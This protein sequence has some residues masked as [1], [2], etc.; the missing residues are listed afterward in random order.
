MERL[1]VSTSPHI[2]SD[3]SVPKIMWTVVISLIPAAAAGCYFFGTRSDGTYSLRPIFVLL[4]SVAVAVTTEAVILFFRGKGARNALDGSAVITGMLFAMVCSSGIPWYIVVLGSFFSIAVA[5][6][7]FGGLGF[8]IWNPALIGRAFALMAWGVEM[9]KRWPV[10]LR[11]DALSGA[12]PLDVLK[13]QDPSVAPYSVWNLFTGNVPGCLGETSALLLLIGGFFLI[14][15]KYVDWRV[16]LS[17][18]VT[19]VILCLVIP[20]KKEMTLSWFNDLSIFEK[21]GYYAFSGGLFLGAFFM[22]TDMVTSPMTKKGALIF[23]IGCGVLTALIRKLGGY[24]EG[25]CYS[26]LLMNTVTPIIDR[27]TKPKKFG[28]VKPQPVVVAGK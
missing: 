8:N 12:T 1:I 28:E 14:A 22:A 23:G 4:G 5:K 18:I 20:F 15:R 24:P 21:A 27:W 3:E 6:Q 10:P 25:V 26:I 2:R 11:A 16:P 7:M 9:G 17:F 19:A 13:T